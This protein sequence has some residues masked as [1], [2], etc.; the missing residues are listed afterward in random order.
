M[1][2][3]LVFQIC[4]VVNNTETGAKEARKLLQKKMLAN[5]PQTQV[6]ALEVSLVV[7]I[8]TRFLLRHPYQLLNA[9]SENCREKFQ[10]QLTA[11]S[12]GEDLD[13]LACSKSNDDRVHGKLVQCLQNWADQYGLDPSYAAIRRI[14]EN[15]MNGVPPS[16]GSGR[17]NLFKAPQVPRQE[18]TAVPQWQKSPSDPLADVELAKNNAQLLSQTLSFTDPTQEDITKNELIQEFYT[19]CQ[20]LQR[21]ISDQLQLCEDENVISALLEANTELLASF[22][23][24]DDM[25]E[26]RAVDEATANSRTLHVRGTEMGHHVG[27]SE[28]SGSSQGHHHNNNNNIKSSQAPHPVSREA[29][30]PVDP[31]DPFGDA[32]EANDEP[33]SSNTGKED[34]SSKRKVEITKQRRQS[35]QQQKT[36]QQ[37]PKKRTGPASTDRTL[38]KDEKKPKEQA[39]KTTTAGVSTNG[40]E[41]Q[42]I[43]ST[44]RMRVRRKFLL[45]QHNG[46][47]EIIVPQTLTHEQQSYQFPPRSRL[48]KK[49]AERRSQNPLM[50]PPPS[51]T[52]AP[53]TQEEEEREANIA[54]Y[55]VNTGQ[56][57]QQQRDLSIDAWIS[58]TAR[59]TQ[60]S[61]TVEQERTRSSTTLA[62]N[63]S[64]QASNRSWIQVQPL[65]SPNL[66]SL[67]ENITLHFQSEA[68]RRWTMSERAAPPSSFIEPPIEGSAR[69]HY[70]PRRLLRKNSPKREHHQLPP[71]EIE[72]NV[73]AIWRE[74]QG[75]TRTTNAEDAPATGM[76]Q[77]V[78]MFE[79]SFELQQQRNQERI[80]RIEYVL[81]EERRRR[82]MA[83]ELHRQSI[84]RLESLE[85]G[86]REN[87]TDASDATYRQLLE[88]VANLQQLVVQ[89]QNARK[90]LEKMVTST[91]QKMDA[92][93]TAFNKETQE[94]QASRRE[95]QRRLDSALNELQTLK[96]SCPGKPKATRPSSMATSAGRRSI[97][98][99][100]ATPAKA[101]VA[102]N[103][104]SR[105]L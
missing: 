21:V 74:Y 67:Q 93:Q 78:K 99:S 60:L 91:V 85:T 82:E 22:K 34:D 80:Q 3:S 64:Q 33:S 58:D 30:T 14:H 28:G 83:E 95:M 41:R 66:R 40:R 49:L 100:A 103:A 47:Q 11:K 62:S 39:K 70:V 4:D 23:A 13:T 52:R 37:E 77:L 45:I 105:P 12:F 51:P 101:K 88:R 98:A 5:N 19:K 26:R 68:G 96:Q 65:P 104:R 89:E 42:G 94:N 81:E 32:N 92:L 69:K 102:N 75:R 1:D 35:G 44:A 71:S 31:F 20:T 15:L 50:S 6:L 7:I 38:S 57:H 79:Q 61:R 86:S 53:Q 56:N 48:L 54:A 16:A 63:P 73:Q 10:S 43:T 18:K 2:W 27:G 36:R 84:A 90:D 9:L 46:G 25:L 8:R 24:Y 87:Q 72:T 55:F 59:S 17:R 29:S 97:H 76:A